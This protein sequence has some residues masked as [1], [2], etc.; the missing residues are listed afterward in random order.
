MRRMLEEF[1]ATYAE[2]Q[3]DGRD[4]LV[5]GFGQGADLTG[6]LEADRSVFFQAWADPNPLPVLESLREQGR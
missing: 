6:D 5:R 2:D 1:F 3:F 4:L